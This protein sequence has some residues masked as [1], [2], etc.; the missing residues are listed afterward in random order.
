MCYK[1]GYDFQIWHKGFPY[2]QNKWQSQVISIVII[3]IK[4]EIF[5]EGGKISRYDPILKG[6]P[7]GQSKGSRICTKK[8]K[9][10][11]CKLSTN[12]ID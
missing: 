5:L 11:E 1:E 6:Y 7:F 9:L 3:C 4:I 8:W 10:T 2:V 12:F